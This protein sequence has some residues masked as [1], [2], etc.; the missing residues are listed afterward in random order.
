MLFGC[1]GCGGFDEVKGV[2]GVDGQNGQAVQGPQG[3]QGSQGP[4]GNGCTAIDRGT[5]IELNCGSTIS[6]LPKATNQNL[7]VCVC[8]NHAKQTLSV[9]L[10]D[11]NNGLYEVLNIGPCRQI[12]SNNPINSSN[13]PSSSG[14]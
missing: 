4:Q 5:Y 7:V 8:I 1:F 14:R 2:K 10:N 9:S 6:I 11:I 3:P 12:S 13:N